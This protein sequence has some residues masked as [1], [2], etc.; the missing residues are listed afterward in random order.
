MA[1]RSPCDLFTMAHAD[2]TP[3]ELSD[4]G[5]RIDLRNT[6]RAIAIGRFA[7]RSAAA[8]PGP[9]EERP[10]SLALAPR[11]SEAAGRGQFGLVYQVEVADSKADSYKAELAQLGGFDD[12]EGS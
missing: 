12:T 4:F 11:R 9:R 6:Q 1:L 7:K 2:T 5:T 3:H 10:G 8:E